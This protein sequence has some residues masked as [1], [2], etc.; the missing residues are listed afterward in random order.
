[1]RRLLEEVSGGLLIVVGTCV[2][3]CLTWIGVIF[4]AELLS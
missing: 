3:L 2:V 1:M 4:L